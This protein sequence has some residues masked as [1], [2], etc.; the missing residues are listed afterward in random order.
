MS[1][2]T[3]T[4]RLPGSRVS[5]APLYSATG[6][7]T[8][9]RSLPYGLEGRANVA[10]KYNSDTNTGADLNPLKRQ[11]EY[12]VVSARVS[13][14]PASKRWSAELW[15]ENLFDENYFQVVYDA[16]FQAGGLE[17]SLGAPRTFGVTLRARY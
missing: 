3:S 15:A 11:G 6:S 8:Y 1:A 13:V 16:P 7:V 14:G 4:V 10:V 2:S 17:A 5:L 9:E 12:A